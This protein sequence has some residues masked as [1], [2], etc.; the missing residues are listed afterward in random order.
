MGRGGCRQRQ[1]QRGAGQA[2][3]Q[4]VPFGAAALD[5]SGFAVELKIDGA[6]IALTDRN[7]VL[8]TGAT[9]G[10]GRIG[11]DVTANLRTIRD[12]P[13][14]LTGSRWPAEMEVRSREEAVAHGKLEGQLLE[15][16]DGVGG[17]SGLEAPQ[18]LAIEVD[19]VGKIARPKAMAAE[20][21]EASDC[22]KPAIC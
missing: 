11:E 22:E 12:I 19:L 17:L 9:R 14:R 10:N 3:R 21:E 7:G 20:R 4:G 5:A 15:P 16:G 8:T 1:Q 6:A 18:R 2:A 13:Q